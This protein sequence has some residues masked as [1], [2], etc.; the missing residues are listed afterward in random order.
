[1]EAASNNAGILYM[2]R[3]SFFAYNAETAAS[4]AFQHTVTLQADKVHQQAMRE[5]D[6]AALVLSKA[7][8]DV[9][10]FQSAD[11]DTPDSIFPNN[12][13]STH[14]DGSLVLYPMMSP[15]RRKERNSGLK[16][17]LVREF[18]ISR[19]L[20]LS[21][22]E[23]EGIF[24]EGTGSIVFDHAGGVA[25]MSVSSRSCVPLLEKLCDALQ[26]QSCVFHGRDRQ[27]KAVYHTNVLLHIG[28][29][30]AVLCE[31]AIAAETEITNLKSHLSQ[32]GKDVIPV[33]LD[34]MENFCG[35]MLQVVNTSG[36]LLTICSDTAFGYLSPQQKKRISLQSEFVVVEVPLI[37]KVGG[38]SIRCMLAEIFL[39]K[40]NSLVQR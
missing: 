30:Y 24:L 40:K 10:I 38:G 8:L 37:E 23:E 28:A 15:N 19:V 3:P 2:V 5:F 33:S 14:R 26:M 27:G 6:N 4:N 7:G 21:S 22:F 12:W 31:D 17:E 35:N 1:M 11:R 13:F 36:E 9:R 25:Y 16:E 18:E 20:D 32:T 39:T 29:G 34:Q